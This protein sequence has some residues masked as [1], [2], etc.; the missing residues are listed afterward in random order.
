MRTKFEGQKIHPQ[1]HIKN[2]PTCESSIT[3]TNFNN[4][5]R[6]GETHFALKSLEQQVLHIH[7]ICSKFQGK[8]RNKKIRY[9]VSTNMCCFET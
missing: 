4:L 5:P 7:K 3:T 8:N 6:I 1:K 9:Q 2:L